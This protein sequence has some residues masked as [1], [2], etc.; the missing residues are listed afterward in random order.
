MRQLYSV[1][2]DRLGMTF[3]P[4][5]RASPSSSTALMTWPWRAV[6][7]SFRASSE[8]IAQPAGI[9]CEPGKP[10]SRRIRSRGIGGQHRQEE[11]QAAELGA[12]RRGAEVELPDIGDIGDGGPRAGGTFVIG[13]ARQAGEAFLLEDH[14]R[15]RPG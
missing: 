13:P 12:E 8:R 5:K 9:I 11:E 15:R 1:R 7:K 4:A 10:A 6:P 3:S 2:K 14:A